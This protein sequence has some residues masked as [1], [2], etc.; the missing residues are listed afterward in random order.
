MYDGFGRP[1]WEVFGAVDAQDTPPAAPPAGV[2]PPPEAAGR[3]AAGKGYDLEGRVVWACD[4]AGAVS[5]F[6][7][8]GF[9]RK[10]KATDPL[11][12][13]VTFA[14]DDADNLRE[15]RDLTRNRTTVITY[16][17]LGRPLFR[18]VSAPGRA[19]G[20]TEGAFAYRRDFAYADLP[21]G[22]LKI[23]ETADPQTPASP[24]PGLKSP[25]AGIGIGVAV[26][27]GIDTG[28]KSEPAPA[29]KLTAADP[30]GPR[31]AGQSRNRSQ[32]RDRE[33]AVR[34]NSLEARGSEGGPKPAASERAF[35]RHDD[36]GTDGGS[37]GGTDSDGDS[38]TDSDTDPDSCKPN[39]SSVVVKTLVRDGFDQA[40][41]ETLSDPANALEIT[42]RSRWDAFG[43]LRE[44]IDPNGNVRTFLR[45]PRG[46]PLV[47]TDGEG[48]QVRRRFNNDGSLAE[49]WRQ[50][51]KSPDPET[52]VKTRF[53]YDALGRKLTDERFRLLECAASVFAKPQPAGRLCGGAFS[54]FFSRASSVTGPRDIA[55]NPYTVA[56]AS[57]VG[58][59]GGG[60]NDTHGESDSEGEG[61]TDSDTDSDTAEP[62]C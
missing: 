12:N 28:S 54:P 22:G 30:Y 58:A 53:T 6:D 57:G 29:L 23:T 25:G 20:E 1:A 15:E 7:Y 5:R 52:G 18:T 43:G 61:D 45:T 46:W 3:F 27:V 37:D 10:V 2:V 62:T 21:S 33:G 38:D 49:E 9:G 55:L 56:A 13:A 35:D 11:G 26:A 48:F 42:R 47:E 4:R 16:D 17:A 36:R 34:L 14:Y 32:S 39:L 8:G 41:S 19:A 59:G 60:D 31:R 40:V 51:S 50:V 24:I 44:E